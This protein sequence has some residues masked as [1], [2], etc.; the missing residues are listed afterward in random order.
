MVEVQSKNAFSMLIKPVRRIIEEKGFVNPTN[1]QIEAIPIILEGKNVLLIAPTGTG[2]TEAAFL[3]IFSKLIQLNHRSLGIKILYIT[4]LRSLNRDLLERLQWWCE[5]LDIK[6]AVRHGDTDSKERSGQSKSPPDILITTPETLQAI[7]PGRNMRQHLRAIR[8]VIIDEVHEFAEDKRG[9][10]LVLALERLRLITENE[11]QIIGLSATIGSPEKIAQF[12]VGT[13]RKVEIVKAPISRSMSIEILNPIPSQIDFNLAAKLY[14][15]PEVAARLRLIR[16]LIE[17]HNSVLLFTNTRS[18]AEVL[19]SR[20]KIWDIDFPVSIHHGS[21]AK[22]SRIT[23]EKGLKEGELKGLI[24]TS[25]LEL[26]IDVGSIDLC[27]QYMS[28]RQVTRLVQ[29]IGRS[30]HNIGRVA[31]GIILTM[32]SEDTMESLVIARK[33]YQ[34]DLELVKIPDKPLDT[35]AHQIVGLLIQAGRWNF[36][37][38]LDVFRKAYPYSTLVEEDLTSILRYMND[39]YPRLA[40]VSFEDKMVMRSKSTKEMYQYYYDNLSMIPDEKNYL[41]VDNTN[42]LPVGVLDEAFVAEHGDLGTKFIER[43]SAWK[44]VNVFNDKI[45]VKPVDDPT[46]AIPSWAGEEIPV[47]FSVAQEVGRI[48]GTVEEHLLNGLTPKEIAAFLKEKYPSDQNTIL[49]A[50]SETLEQVES[51]FKIPTDKRVTIEEW[52]EFIVIHAC[53][54]SL[55]NRTLAILL[56]HIL[57]ERSG[58]TVGIQEDS[59]R[60]IIQAAMSIDSKKVRDALQELSTMSIHSVAVEA[61]VKTGLFKRRIINIARKFGA[62]SKQADFS[63]IS[64]RQLTKSFQGT[65]IFDEAVRETLNSD[66]DIDGTSSVLRNIL[67]SNIEVVLLETDKEATPIGRLGLEKIGM[68]YN[69]IPPEKMKLITLESTKARLL[70]ET[71]TLVCTSC[72]AFSQ[73]IYIRELSDKVSCPKC[74][75]M[76][77]GVV[78]ELVDDIQRIAEKRGKNLSGKEKKIEKK[79]LETAELMS[80]YSSIAALV[81]AGK[82]LNLDEVEEFLSNDAS[83]DDRLFELIIEAEKKALSRRF[84]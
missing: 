75:S 7:I 14:T 77:I 59:Y 46:G 67:G 2:K 1:P 53:F 23:A 47:P 76:K 63:S 61:I 10:H 50:L 84:W 60:I 43:G 21:L 13:N 51:G 19:A 30:G 54:G 81:L 8:W 32:D 49:R 79:A 44:I 71:K 64:L 41:V 9:C 3:P 35:L 6:V 22:P 52:N 5:K 73:T 72:W 42:E 69:L 25:S 34:E 20:F 17:N 62:V 15:H 26:G 38:I 11:F 74:S 4:P 39:R 55:I 27:I 70:S 24:C 33:A 28:P 83:A 65:A 31:E 45:Y 40:W 56:G 80:K 36:N 29:R 68:R 48:R 12:L 57:S 18:I 66:L 16:K 78:D 58:Y 37:Q 82:N